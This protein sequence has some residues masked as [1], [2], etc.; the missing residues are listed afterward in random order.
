MTPSPVSLRLA[1]ASKLSACSDSLDSVLVVA[2]R[3]D[4]DHEHLVV[5]E[6]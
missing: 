1:V 3:E 5:D 4:R 2:D 6:A